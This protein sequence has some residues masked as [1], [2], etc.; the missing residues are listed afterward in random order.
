MVVY[1]TRYRLCEH[2]LYQRASLSGG[3]R[4][5]MRGRKVWCARV[6]QALQRSCQSI[7][8]TCLQLGMSEREQLHETSRTESR[9]ALSFCPHPARAVLVLACSLSLTFKRRTCENRYRYTLHT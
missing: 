8:G 7:V 4:N 9:A 1:R 3:A 2:T 5:L 6:L